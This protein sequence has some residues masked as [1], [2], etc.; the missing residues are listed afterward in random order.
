MGKLPLMYF[1]PK[2]YDLTLVCINHLIRSLSNF[3]FLE[4]SIFRPVT[5]EQF[6]Y[7]KFYLPRVLVYTG[8]FLYDKFYLPRVLV[9]TEQFLYDKVVNT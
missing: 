1:V 5:D 2:E 6:L 9:Y 8:Q 7:D 4:E 3:D